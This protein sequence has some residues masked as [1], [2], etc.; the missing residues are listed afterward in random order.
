MN[1]ATKKAE[2]KKMVKSCCG[3]GGPGTSDPLSPYKNSYYKKVK[4]AQA[5][6]RIAK[7]TGLD[8]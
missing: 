2:L 6:A 4:S 1:K 3:K 8:N 5:F 7:T